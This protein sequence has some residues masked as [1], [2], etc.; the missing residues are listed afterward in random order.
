MD[1]F[2]LKE[3][4]YPVGQSANQPASQP[5]VTIMQ[6]GGNYFVE[7]RSDNT[8]WVNRD[9][10]HELVALLWFADLCN[11][12]KTFDQYVAAVPGDVVPDPE[13]DDDYDY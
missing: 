9:A 3:N 13:P 2:T 4:M 11:G 6:S 7:V 12:A 10:M 1:Y 5:S 8:T